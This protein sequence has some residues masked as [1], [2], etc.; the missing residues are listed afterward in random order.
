[1]SWQSRDTA[2]V[3][4]PRLSSY[5]MHPSTSVSNIF[6]IIICLQDMD[7]HHFMQCELI[8]CRY[9]GPMQRDRAGACCC[10]GGVE[11]VS[12]GRGR[13][14]R[15]SVMVRS[16]HFDIHVFPSSASGRDVFLLSVMDAIALQ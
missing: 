8:I 14:P 7:D 9:H 16:L 6:N 5:L 11:R 13:K 15:G 10:V 3:F 4:I 1:M 2:K 12:C